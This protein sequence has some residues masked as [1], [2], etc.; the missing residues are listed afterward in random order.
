MK[1]L[2]L[3]LI[4]GFISIFSISCEG[5]CRTCTL[6]G[7]AVVKWDVCDRGNNEVTIKGYLN[8]VVTSEEISEGNVQSHI[9]AFEATGYICN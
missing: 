6:N 2:S 4:L 8:G 3:I 5:G 9:A 7:V 1:K